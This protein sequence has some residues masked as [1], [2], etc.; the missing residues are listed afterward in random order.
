M[1]FLCA[2]ES[3]STVILG[4]Y[5]YGRW[6]YSVSTAQPREPSTPL[7]EQWRRWHQP[8]LPT[9]VHRQRRLPS[10]AS[11]TGPALCAVY[12]VHRNTP[13][14]ISRSG[15]NLSPLN[16]R[17]HPMHPLPRRLFA[18]IRGRPAMPSRSHV[19]AHRRLVFHGDLHTASVQ[20]LYPILDKKKDPCWL[21]YL[22]ST[23]SAWLR[24]YPKHLTMS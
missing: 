14:P 11:R 23:P 12:Y 13:I 19:Q 24:G 20:R 3:V 1:Y 10:K 5:V 22:T 18:R 17:L 8:A 9:I 7:L 21:C 6:T 16:L 4:S 2:V 15:W